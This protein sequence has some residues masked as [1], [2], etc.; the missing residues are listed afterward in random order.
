MNLIATEKLLSGY[1]LCGVLENWDGGSRKVCPSCVV[2]VVRMSYP[3]SD[4]QDMG[5]CQSQGKQHLKGSGN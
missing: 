4:G 5:L 2:L 3:A 1:T